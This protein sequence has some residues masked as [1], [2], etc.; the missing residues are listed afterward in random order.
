MNCDKKVSSSS[1]LIQFSTATWYG[2]ICS[3]LL[4]T[5][6]QFADD[7]VILLLYLLICHSL[8]RWILFPVSNYRL[9]WNQTTIANW[10][11]I[12]DY[13]SFLMIFKQNWPVALKRCFSSWI[14]SLTCSS[15][16]LRLLS[17]TALFSLDVDP[18]LRLRHRAPDS[19]VF[20]WASSFCISLHNMCYLFTDKVVL[21]NV[22]SRSQVATCNASFSKCR[23][24][25]TS[26]AVAASLPIWSRASCSSFCRNPFCCF[27]LV[28]SS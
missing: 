6:S 16:L 18:P 7:L 26:A 1:L 23:F 17:R 13:Y 9:K 20:N 24:F 8:L 3:V 2:G 21:L 4:E 10:S 27:S 28:I 14:S 11:F 25:S 12:N 5:F 22:H 15:A 19:C